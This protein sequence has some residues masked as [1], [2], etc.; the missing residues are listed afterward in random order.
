VAAVLTQVETKQIRINIHK[1]QY[2]TV[3]TIQNTA[4]T[5]THI[6]KTPTQL[7]KHPHITEHTHT[8]KRYKIS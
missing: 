3:P 6:T 4:R 8:P 5:G 1:K 2:N 7:V